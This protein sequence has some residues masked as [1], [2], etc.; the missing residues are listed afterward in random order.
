MEEIL[1]AL[2]GLLLKAVPTFILVVLVHFYLKGLFYRPMDRILKQRDE[3]TEGARKLAAATLQKAS[4]RAAEYEAALQAARNEMY[5]EQEEYRR[6]WRQEQ[7]EA[8]EEVRH[9][10]GELVKRARERLAGEVSEAKTSLVAQSEEL[11]GQI[12]DSI[13]KGSV[14]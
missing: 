11:A 6:K 13:L 10:A 8:L 14:N 9:K 7:A 5:K 4:E 1:Q 12:A 3:A 2:G